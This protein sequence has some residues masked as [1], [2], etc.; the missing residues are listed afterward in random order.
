MAGVLLDVEPEDFVTSSSS[1]SSAAR[2]AASAG[3]RL[4]SALSGSTQMAGSDPAGLKWA[5][6]YDQ[7]AADAVRGLDSLE[8]VLGQVSAGL[9]VTGLNYATADWLSAGHS[10]YAPG[11]SV[12]SLPGAICSSPPPSSAGGSRK[13]SIPGFEYVANFI[14]EMWP[15]GDTGKLHAAKSA[16]GSFADDLDSIR[17]GDITRIKSGLDGNHT[18]ELPTIDS[19]ITS[20]GTAA[21]KLADEARNLATACGKLATEIDHVHQQ[22]EQVLNS[23]VEQLAATAAVGIGLT[24]FTA[25]LSDGAA[26][27]AGGGEIAAAVAR[28]LGFIAEL[29]TNVARVV[30]DIA[31]SAGSIAKVAG[32][33]E[34]ITIRVVTIAGKSVVTGV[35]GAF[36]NVGVQ[37]I[38]DPG[39]DINAAAVQGFVGGAAFGVLADGARLAGT[40]L[41][42]RDAAKA[43]ETARVSDFK[44]DIKSWSAARGSAGYK[45]YGDLGEKKWFKT[46]FQ[47]FDSHGYAEWKWP[48]GWKGFLNGDS[49]P[50]QLQVGDRITRLSPVGRDGSFATDPG[51]AFEAM[52][53]PPDRLAP[54][55]VQTEYEV[56]KPLPPYVREGAID[57][58]FEQSGLGKQYFFPNKMKP[59]VNAGY[60]REAP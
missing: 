21:G 52:S 13:S 33:S 25:G 57:P 30:D 51:T 27:L 15:D 28:I 12:P 32:I 20:I 59:L 50:N 58:G 31:V 1:A 18:P 2:A 55:Y 4:R 39:T 6:Q 22:T 41:G 43:V 14:G 23:L 24:I 19:T 47:G 54:N 49:V 42:A 37:E 40:A 34:Q 10:G 46:Y 26:A 11:Y 5:A 29:G 36:T 44:A 8:T 48:D 3:S 17:S 35:G 45:P 7:V 38:V 16:W 9:A 56:L 53:L 60:L